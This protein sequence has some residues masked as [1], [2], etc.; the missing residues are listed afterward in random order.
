VKTTLIPAR[1]VLASW[2]GGQDAND[3]GVAPLSDQDNR[4]M[5]TD[6]INRAVAAVAGA[7]F[8]DITTAFC[9]SQNLCMYRDRDQ[10]LYGD[11]MHIS[12]Y[13]SFFALRDFHYPA[14]AEVSR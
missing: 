4:R 13:G 8:V 9:N 2:L 3:P 6:V 12:R 14:L 11:T 5:S 1:R 7:E 10:L